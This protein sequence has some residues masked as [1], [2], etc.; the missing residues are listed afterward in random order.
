MQVAPLPTNESARLR[1]LYDYRILDSIPEK[2]FDQITQI[3]AEICHTPISC[4]GLIDKTRQWYKS[5]VGLSG[6][7]TPR[8]I[9]FCAHA[10]LEPD[11]IMVVPDARRDARFADNPLTTGEPFVQFYAGVPLVSSE[12]YA[13]GT[14]CVVDHQPKELTE[15]QAA[16]LRALA[17][18]TVTRFEL[19]QRTLELEE[20]QRKL[21]TLNEELRAATERAEAIAQAKSDFLSIMSHEIRTPIHTILGY[22]GILL[23]ENPR[24]DQESS[25]KTLQFSGQTLLALLNDILDFSKLD[26]GKVALESIPFQ[27]ADLVRQIISTNVPQA[28]VKETELLADLDPALPTTLLGDPVRLVQILNNLISNA[29]KFTSQGQV[30]I[31]VRVLEQNARHATLRFAI[32]DSGVGIPPE[33]HERIFEDFSQ[34]SPA[35]SRKFGGT[36]LGLSITRKL[37]RLFGSEIEL[38]SAVGRGSTFSFVVRFQQT[39]RTVAVRPTVPSQDLSGYRVLAVDDNAINLKLIGHHLAKKGIDADLFTS[40]LDALRAVEGKTYDLLFLDLQMPEMSG[41][42][43]SV[44]IRQ[45]HLTVPIIALSADTSPETI[46][47]VLRVG[48]NGFMAKPYT[49]DKM[50]EVLT[51]YLLPDSVPA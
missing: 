36:G 51:Q 15:N 40:P 44:A 30:R 3:A 41:F 43:L 49:L 16:A 42:E 14:L 37:L 24:P 28:L 12:G 4:I 25:L 31:S 11:R 45:H 19:R 48:M 33:A 47:A 13:V 2:E 5:S 6:S 10:I 39:S 38:D 46:S 1:A 17:D 32:Q 18:Q 27:P 20:A 7:E 9:S 21:T 29:V 50:Q 22:T 23:E 34:A 35:T 26:A 8:D